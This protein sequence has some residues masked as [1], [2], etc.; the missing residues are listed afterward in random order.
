[1]QAKQI[2]I[3]IQVASVQLDQSYNN[4]VFNAV[5]IYMA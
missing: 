3:L 2:I 5:S 4:F 1:M